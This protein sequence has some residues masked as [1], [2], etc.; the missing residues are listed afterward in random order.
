ML[1]TDTPLCI[2][3]QALQLSDKQYEWVTVR[4]LAR[5]HRWSEVEQAV[6][7]PKTLFRAAKIAPKTQLAQLIRNLKQA[8]APPEVSPPHLDVQPCRQ[9]DQ[10]VF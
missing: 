8:G 2:T 3:G 7:T 1:F 6:T 9:S 5:R 4:T 10:L